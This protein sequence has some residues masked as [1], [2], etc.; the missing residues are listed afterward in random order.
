MIGNELIICLNQNK[1]VCNA[2]GFRT[3][4]TERIVRGDDDD[5][6]GSP[7]SSLLIEIFIKRF[8]SRF[9][10]ICSKLFFTASYILMLAI[11]TYNSY[12]FC[13][14]F[15]EKKNRKQQKLICFKFEIE[16]HYSIKSS[17]LN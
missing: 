2:D 13:A 1:T 6:I 12:S 11:L 15:Y 8:C 9:A 5:D 7:R 16:K 10:F 17:T 4:R 14:V 3:E